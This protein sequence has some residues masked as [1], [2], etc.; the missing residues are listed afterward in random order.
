MVSVC[1]PF[2]LLIFILQTRAGLRAIKRLGNLIARNMGLW[3]DRSRTRHE[4]RLQLQQQLVQAAESQRLSSPSSSS[5]VG[6]GLGAG[7]GA[8]GR[9]VSLRKGRVRR[10]GGAPPAQQHDKAAVGFQ[11]METIDGVPD[12][13][14]WWPW[15][16]RRKKAED[17]LRKSTGLNV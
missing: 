5:V 11:T 9:R 1:V 6:V 17:M 2:F 13:Q 14:G 3:N 16:W 15:G 8:G 12:Q 4:R 7:S 10:P